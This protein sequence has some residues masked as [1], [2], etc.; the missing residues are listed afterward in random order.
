MD[1]P[2]AEILASK[3]NAV[4]DTMPAPIFA[5]LDGA[6]FDDVEEEL[7]E[8]GITARSLFLEG[9][10]D[11]MRRDGPWLITVPEGD[12]RDHIVGLAAATP[13]AVFWS[14]PDGEQ[15]L[16]RHLRTINEV[17]IP[18]EQDSP[19]SPRPD[20]PVSYETVLFRHWDPNVL[21]S[22]VP[23]MEAP[24]FARL[25][26]PAQA[27]VMNATEHGGLKRALLHRDHPAAPPG[28]LRFEP[29]QMAAIRGQRADRSNREVGDYLRDTLPPALLDS[30]GD[31]VE[32]LVQR[33][34]ATGKEL[35]IQTLSGHKRWA[36]L[37]AMTQGRAAETKEATDFIRF[38]G[39]SPD[40]QVK[41][42]IGHTA[43]ALRSAAKQG[44]RT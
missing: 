3:L 38:G 1:A 28:L 11:V 43:T 15:A 9:G 18:D 36:Y 13:C 6:R 23:L 33:A 27:I 8:V 25:L 42:L 26:G 4:I 24:Q 31:D 20:R 21:G 7:A 44:D 17:L 37:M 34:R 41:A 5:V 30:M 19:G 12:V 35:G 16:W 40:A 2:D 39:T 10:N 29:E 14:C 32:P 22:L